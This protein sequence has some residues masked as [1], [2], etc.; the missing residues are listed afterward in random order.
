M[1]ITVAATQFACTDDRERNLATAE[2][3]IRAA[4]AQGANIILIQE[5]FET[6]Y[7]CKDQRRRYFSLA[8]SMDESPA[9]RRFQEL[10]RELERRAAGKRV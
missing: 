9:V 7:F 5:L 3:L 10:A 1:P 8:R 4:A 2:R 6:P